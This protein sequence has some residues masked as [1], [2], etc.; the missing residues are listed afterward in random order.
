MSQ[1]EPHTKDIGD[2]KY[3][4]YM[5]PPMESHN[6]LMD[7]TKMIGPSIGPVIDVVFTH[8]MDAKLS[9]D[10]FSKVATTL[11]GDLN[12]TVLENVIKVFKKVTEIDNKPLGPIFD[13][14]FMGKLEDMYQWIAWGMGVQWGKSLGVLIGS[15]ADQDAS[16]KKE[17]QSRTD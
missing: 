10:F 5:L 11:F 14:H 9:G 15:I 13:A 1:V 17:S 8:G 4:M 12:K 6:L 7:V 3:T 2:N 16:L